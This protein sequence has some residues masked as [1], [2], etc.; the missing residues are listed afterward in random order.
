MLVYLIHCLLFYVRKCNEMLDAL[1]QQQLRKKYFFRYRRDNEYETATGPLL[2]SKENSFQ[3]ISS[4]PLPSSQP[5]YPRG[6]ILFAAERARLD[7]HLE[8][9][10][11]SA[12]RPATCGKKGSWGSLCFFLYG[13]TLY[14]WP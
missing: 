2:G 6:A 9:P 12:W 7:H 3:A 4:S 10:P 14:R 1:V 11:K 8:G 5:P 13:N